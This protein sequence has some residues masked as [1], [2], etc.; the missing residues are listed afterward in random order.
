MTVNTFW[1]TRP[2]SNE[3]TLYPWCTSAEICRAVD[4]GII[5][6]TNVRHGA[7]RCRSAAFDN[8]N[9]VQASN[10]I[11]ETGDYMA[12]VYLSSQWWRATVIASHLLLLVPAT[13]AVLLIA[14]QKRCQIIV[15]ESRCDIET[16]IAFDLHLA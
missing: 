9:M 13:G 6:I 12:N 7:S 16:A 14:I 8:L 5:L 3:A 10:L 15:C 1:I 4:I 2:A 11:V